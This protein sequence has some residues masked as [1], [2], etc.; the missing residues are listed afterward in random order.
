MRVAFVALGCE[1][2]AI[3]LLGAILRR[4]GHQVGLAFSR[5]LFDDR[6]FMHVP[7]LAKVFADDDVIDQLRQFRPDVVCFSS[8]TMTHRW[9]LDVAVQVKEQLGATTIFGGVH[10]SAV[11]E[12]V[13]AE[14]GVDYVL[15]SEG[16]IALPMLIDALRDG[17]L[18][19]A[20][21][22]VLWKNAA[23]K[24]VR[25][26]VLPFFQDLDLL[27]G[28]EKDLWLE[29]I[30]VDSFYLTMSARGCPYRCSYCF[31]NF[32]A[33]LPGGPRKAGKYVRQ[34]SVDHFIAELVDAKRKYNIRYVDIED[35]IFTLDT[36]WT[37]EF[38]RRYKKEV[39][40]PFRCLSH[41][42]WLDEPRVQALKEAGCEWVQIGVETADDDYKRVVRRTESQSKVDKALTLM[43]KAGINVKTDH[44][45]GLPGES[46]GAQEKAL[47]FYAAHDI[48]R[49]GTFWLCYMPGTEIVDIGLKQGLITPQ[50][51]EEVNQ[52]KSTFFF[53]DANVADDGT[54]R[55]YLAYEAIFRTMPL[56]PHKIRPMIDIDQVEKLPEPVLRTTGLVA[57][58]LASTIHRNPE[59]R[60]YMDQYMHG[61]ENHV[62]QRLGMEP[63]RR[64][65]PSQHAPISD[66]KWDEA[67]D[68]AVQ[69]VQANLPLAG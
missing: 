17:P 52:G 7:S 39:G 64:W 40:V 46:M 63:K 65:G 12:T 15:V 69:A 29:H 36:A 25:G 56:L 19:K 5:H 6:L 22:N 13:L 3:S 23:G 33:N 35:D 10:P 58:A 67:Y 14:P 54:R 32:F 30:R 4:A 60:N 26:P 59:L 18:T 9:M 48:S 49:I 57:D 42:H 16:D 55:R 20:M 62:R 53:R 41:A 28:Y 2:L 37:Q 21:P 31:N 61:L 47:D 1:Q 68:A 11:P 43:A 51:V 8:L 38:S 44:I 24:I 45:F 50:Q 66:A 34:R 27:P